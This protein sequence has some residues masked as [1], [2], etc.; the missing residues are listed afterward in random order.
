[1]KKIIEGALM[2][3]SPTPETE[4][5]SNPTNL[6][7]YVGIGASAG[8]L[9]ALEDFFKKCHSRTDWHF[10]RSGTFLLTIKA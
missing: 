1:L 3:D 9:E 7:Y 10:S 6:L 8:G 2:T 4:Q 5:S